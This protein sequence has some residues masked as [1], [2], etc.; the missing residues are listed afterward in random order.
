MSA[1]PQVVNLIRLSLDP[2]SRICGISL[3]V[4]RQG[5][6]RILSIVADTRR[7]VTPR[8]APASQLAHSR[9]GD[10]REAGT[11]KWP[12][13]IDFCCFRLHL[14]A[15]GRPFQNPSRKLRKSIKGWKARAYTC[16]TV[17]LCRRQLKAGYKLLKA[18]KQSSQQP[19]CPN[20]CVSRSER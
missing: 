19:P 7:S 2:R 17:G 6:M 3:V 4:R 18:A 11:E 9:S 14:N 1:T 10:M 5:S 12:G 13:L 15:K 20:L 8:I 16:N